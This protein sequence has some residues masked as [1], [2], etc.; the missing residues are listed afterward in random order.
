VREGGRNGLCERRGGPQREE[1]PVAARGKRFRD[2]QAASR[3]KENENNTRDQAGRREQVTTRKKLRGVQLRTIYR[4]EG[5]SKKIRTS[6]TQGQQGSRTR[7]IPSPEKK[8]APERGTRRRKTGK[9]KESKPSDQEDTP[10]RALRKEKATTLLQQEGSPTPMTRETWET[11]GGN[12][13]ERKA[14]V[15]IAGSMGGVLNKTSS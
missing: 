4:S 2:Q 8:L 14:R 6:L 9:G 3:P 1:A 13:A 15:R 11:S 5:K 7:V 10:L 12:R